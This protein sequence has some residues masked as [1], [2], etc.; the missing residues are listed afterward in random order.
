MDRV[1]ELGNAFSAPGLTGIQNIVLVDD[2]YTTG[3]TID[4]LAKVLKASGIENVYF[5]AIAIVDNL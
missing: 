5:V 4:T 2:I 3:S 1:L